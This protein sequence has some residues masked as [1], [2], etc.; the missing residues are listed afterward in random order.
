M[1][2]A[3]SDQACLFG[4]SEGA[5]MSV[6][7]AATYPERVSHLVLYSGFAAIDWLP[8]DEAEVLIEAGLAPWGDGS[9][10]GSVLAPGWADDAHLR[11]LLARYER[12]SATPVTA[13]QAIKVALDIDVTHI[14]PAINMPTLVLH[15]RGDTFVPFETSELLADLIPDAKLIELPGEDHLF[16]AGNT[17]DI[18]DPVDEFVTG[19]TSRPP[20]TTR[21]LATILFTDIVA[22]TSTAADMGDKQWTSLLTSIHSASEAVVARHGG[23]LIKQ[24]GDGILATFDGPARA[25]QCGREL[26]DTA[27]SL[28]VELRAGL[29]TAEIELVDDDIAGIGV[30]IASRVAGSAAGGE[31]WASRTVR[32]LVA[33]SGL[34]FE[35]R[36]THELSGVEE[37]WALYAVV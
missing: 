16:G 2:D 8:R 27:A 7:F 29:H 22:S 13:V 17:D 14:L 5:A 37:P 26:I 9:V 25:V 11:Q 24:L 19:T 10:F 32:D 35:D 33:G 20:E 30:H 31:L 3:G 23:R 21:V 28:G 1:N 18:L 34:S 4:V 36:G 6:L 12:N 15:R